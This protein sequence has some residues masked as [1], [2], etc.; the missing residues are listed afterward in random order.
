MSD[1][2]LQC[3]CSRLL[4]PSQS[5]VTYATTNRPLATLL[6]SRTKSL[7]H[8]LVLT[9]VS[10]GTVKPMRTFF[11]SFYEYTEALKALQSDIIVNNPLIPVNLLRKLDHRLLKKLK[12]SQPTPTE[13][14][15][16]HTL[17]YVPDITHSLT[18]NAL[19][20]RMLV[21][22]QHLMKTKVSTIP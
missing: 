7:N 17:P 22:S 18:L 2:R 4:T 1:A 9:S 16:I 3:G 10:R 21:S 5:S 15:E 11:N 20:L 14:D 8:L 6:R 19:A 13:G 12:H